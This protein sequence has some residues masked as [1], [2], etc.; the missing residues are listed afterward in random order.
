M[1]LQ[2][3]AI[4]AMRTRF[5]TL[6]ESGLFVMPNAWDAASAKVMAT[7]GASAVAT[8]SSGFAATLGRVDY[9][10]TAEEL[11]R[12]S[13]L[14]CETAGVPVNVD[15]ERCFGADSRGVADFVDELGATGAA[16]F[17]IED[18]NPATESIDPIDTA[19]ERVA[20]AAEAAADHGMTLTARAERHL[21]ESDADF[22][23]TLT[24]LR[25]FA[26]AGAGCIYAPGL[27]DPAQIAAVCALGPPVNVLIS[28]ATPTVN[29]LADLGVRRVSTGGAL[30]RV[31]L[32]EVRRAIDELIGSGT[33]NYMKHAIDG[34]EFD[35]M[36][37]N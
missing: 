32:G 33:L 17:S 31:A 5:S 19:V 16:G 37:G 11:L 12:H 10:V 21:Y 3:S 14:M 36:L 6:H 30:T 7:A 4:E 23:D 24:R 34:Q 26:E 28:P 13:A 1:S 25:L 18:F 29:E 20:A 35:R 22:D 8:T 9:E 2:D 15:S 27:R